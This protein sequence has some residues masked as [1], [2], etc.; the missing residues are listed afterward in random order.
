MKANIHPQFN[1]NITVTCSCGNSFVSG[2]TTGKDMH[3]DVCYKCHP[4][5]SGE[6]RFLDVRGRVEEFKKR[7]EVAKTYRATVKSKKS[8]KANDKGDNRPKTLRE[9]LGEV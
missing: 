3:V 8:N 1:D 4:F 9:L 7:Q 2:S 6:Q 5:Y